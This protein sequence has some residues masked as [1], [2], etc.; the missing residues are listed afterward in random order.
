MIPQ[1]NN[2]KNTSKKKVNIKR[3]TAISTEKVW[4]RLV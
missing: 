1:K 2:I 3:K 4:K